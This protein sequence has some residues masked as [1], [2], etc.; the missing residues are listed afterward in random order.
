M[1]SATR[2]GRRAT[3]D[4]PAIVHTV[5]VL[6]LIQY[7]YHSKSNHTTLVHTDC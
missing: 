6:L 7:G 5:I 1:L 4:I 2:P 3:L